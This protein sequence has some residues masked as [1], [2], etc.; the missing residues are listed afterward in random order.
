[1]KNIN[2]PEQLTFTDENGIEH[3]VLS[4]IFLKTA[5]SLWG[6]TFMERLQ[7]YLSYYK[8]YTNTNTNN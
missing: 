2:I 1:M 4:K 5:E 7:N 6:K 8:A 3:K